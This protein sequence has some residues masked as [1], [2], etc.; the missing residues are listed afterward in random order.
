MFIDYAKI[1][2]RAG[3][4]G[5]GCSSF[6]REKYVPYGG[7]DGGDGGKGGD[8]IIMTDIN[9]ATLIDFKYKRNYKAERGQHGMGKN[10]YGKNG[11][12]IIIKVPIGTVIKENGVAIYDLTEDGNKIIIAKG[13]GGGRGNTHFKT[14]TNQA[15]TY[16]E[17]G[18]KGEEKIIELELKVLADVGL[19]GF[20]N[21]G[22]S[23]LLSKISSA[24]PKIA[25][26]PFTTLF[27]NLGTVQNEDFV[28]FVVADIPG[29]IEGAHEGK[30]LG[31]EF[32]KHIERTKIL[33][34]MIE[35]ITENILESYKKL[36]NEVKLFKKEIL[37]KPRI[38]VISKID[39][40][41]NPEKLDPVL[42]EEIPII[43]ISS[44]SGKGLN[45][46]INAISNLLKNENI[47]KVK[48]F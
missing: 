24:K 35:S 33:I 47:R 29:L 23:T 1:K 17:V 32:L 42:D 12:D 19:V 41:E 31:D 6:R 38:L 39:L 34:F 13:G 15:P 18:E 22:K 21:S 26:Y 44:I 4:G 48:K 3:D 10:K 2:V 20:P 9:I 36:K 25:E 27:P 28:S 43:K 40:I 16:W 45:E 14:S 37:N 7:P 8:V 11:K 46:L 5:S 30:G